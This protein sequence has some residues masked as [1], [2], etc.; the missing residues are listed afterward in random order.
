MAAPECE[1]DRVTRKLGGK[2]KTAALL[3]TSVSGVSKW[4]APKEKGGAGGRVPPKHAVTLLQLGAID[5]DDLDPPSRD[6]A[7]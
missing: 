3:N 5:L 7:A 2:T 4:S 1:S 6:E